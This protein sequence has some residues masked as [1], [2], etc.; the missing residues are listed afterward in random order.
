MLLTVDYQYS[1]HFVQGLYLAGGQQDVVEL[2]AVSRHQ[3]QLALLVGRAYYSQSYN[4]CVI[5]TYSDPGIIDS[6]SVALSRT[7]DPAGMR[8]PMACPS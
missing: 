3:S 7:T 1:L 6:G 4:F 5:I 2:A 8:S